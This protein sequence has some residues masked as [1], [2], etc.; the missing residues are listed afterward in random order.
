MDGGD[1]CNEGY[2]IRRRPSVR[3]YVKRVMVML[4]ERSLSYINGIFEHDAHFCSC[5]ISNYALMFWFR[6]KEEGANVDGT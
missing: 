5:S 4:M 2:D 3:R 1:D 6:W